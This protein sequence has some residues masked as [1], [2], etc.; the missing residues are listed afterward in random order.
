M[1]L[2]DGSSVIGPC[3]NALAA[4]L[5]SDNGDVKL[6]YGSAPYIGMGML[7]SWLQPDCFYVQ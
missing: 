2:P 3:F 6:P 5:C 4:P 1:P 7:V